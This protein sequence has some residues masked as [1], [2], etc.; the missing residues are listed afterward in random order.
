[1]YYVYMYY[2]RGGQTRSAQGSVLVIAAFM[3][4]T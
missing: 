2:I 4:R 1:M 3:A